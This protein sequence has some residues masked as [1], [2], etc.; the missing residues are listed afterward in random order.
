MLVIKGTGDHQVGLAGAGAA[1]VLGAVDYDP[2]YKISDAFTD[3]HPVRVL[4]GTI[5]VL[6][7]VASQTIAKGDKLMAAANGQV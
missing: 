5:V 3:K 6:T 7:L 2:R 1:N 4:K